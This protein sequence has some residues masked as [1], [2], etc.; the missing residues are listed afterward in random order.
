MTERIIH[1]LEIIEINDEQCP[2]ADRSAFEFGKCGMISGPIG[3]TGQGV[4]KSPALVLEDTLMS[5]DSDLREVNTVSHHLA[6]EGRRSSGAT[7]VESKCRDR[8]TLC[9]TYR[10]GPAR[11]KPVRTCE[12]FKLRPAGI[13][14]DINDA[15]ICFEIRSSAA[16]AS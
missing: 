11:A 3:A 10:T 7:I 12:V 5:L 8:T 9:I 6:F 13:G 15:D 2:T 4:G 1:D 14:F 16:R